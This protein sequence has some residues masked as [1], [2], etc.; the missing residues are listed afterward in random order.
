M[1]LWEKFAKKDA[2]YYIL[3]YK[4]VDY[5]SEEGQQYFYRTGKELMDLFLV[6]AE[7]HLR[8]KKSALEI[9]CGIGRLTIPHSGVF[10]KISA[11]DISPTMLAK[12]KANAL[13]RNITNIEGFLPDGSWDKGS[14]DYVYSSIVFQHIADWNI[15]R[16]YI[17]RISNC[18]N[19]HGIIQIQ[20]DTRPAGFLYRL[21]NMIPDFL[22][23]KDQ[24]KGIRRIRRT[25]K[26]LRDLFMA[27]NLGILE[28]FNPDD[29]NHTFIL[30]KRSAI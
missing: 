7:G 15:I 10:E 22:L 4:N 30:K 18:I 28:E 5:N 2:E 6:R 23:P 21:R 11:V 25:S 13:K 26:E 27:N 29:E 3:S 24:R 19:D 16:N 1:N 12:L 8:A 14:Y 9:G 20:F 17:N